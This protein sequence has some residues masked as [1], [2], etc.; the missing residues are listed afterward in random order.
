MNAS[1]TNTVE[2]LTVHDERVHKKSLCDLETSM[3]KL[4]HLHLA[5]AWCFLMPYEQFVF[6]KDTTHP[7]IHERPYPK[8]C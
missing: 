7:N 4:H 3:I 5:S 1:C 6:K 8:Y 2:I